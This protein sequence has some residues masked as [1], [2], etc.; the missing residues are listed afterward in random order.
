MMRL[1]SIANGGSM[2]P[3]YIRRFQNVRHPDSNLLH[4]G[5]NDSDSSRERSHSNWNGRFS[6]QNAPKPGSN[7]RQR[8]SN[9]P[10]LVGNRLDS[11][12]NEVRSGRKYIWRAR[13]CFIRIRMSDILVG[14]SDVFTE[15]VLT[16]TVVASA[17]LKKHQDCFEKSSPRSRAMA[18]PIARSPTRVRNDFGRPL[19]TVKSP[20][21]GIKKKGLN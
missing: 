17:P 5:L 7:G 20:W 15:N 16:Q 21:S 18:A 9:V 14:A 1:S 2:S 6:D 11:V 13:I 3:K 19:G 10:H 4:S 8:L 12:P